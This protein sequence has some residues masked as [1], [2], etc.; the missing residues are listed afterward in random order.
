M[1]INIKEGF[2]IHR[3]FLELVNQYFAEKYLD[4]HK[5]TQ[6]SRG[7]QKFIKIEFSIKVE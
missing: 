4:Y 1:K 6:E 7:D 3:D 5:I 2:E